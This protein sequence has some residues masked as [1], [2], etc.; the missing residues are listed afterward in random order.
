[1]R[2]RAQPFAAALVAL[3]L[4][5]AIAQKVV[6]REEYYTTNVIKASSD[7]PA[8]CKSR[9]RCPIKR[10]THVCNVY[11]GGS[12]GTF[13]KRTVPCNNAKKKFNQCLS[14]CRS[15]SGRTNRNI[16]ALFVLKAGKAAIRLFR[17]TKTV[18]TKCFRHTYSD[19]TFRAWCGAQSYYS[20]WACGW[21]E[22]GCA[23]ACN[24]AGRNLWDFAL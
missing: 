2:Q 15:V 9:T 3:C 10:S 11:K 17:L 12:C 18:R 16:H 14:Q 19:G 4:L 22:S 20:C 21:L 13:C 6:K 7:L 5:P 24:G 1:M 8:A 23:S